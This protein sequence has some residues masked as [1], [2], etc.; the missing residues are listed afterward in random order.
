MEPATAATPVEHAALTIRGLTKSFG[1]TQA[2]AAVDLDLPRGEILALLGQNGAGKSTLVKILAG[3]VNPDAGEIR[4]DGEIHDFEQGRPSIAFIH[5]DLGLIEWM[6]VAENI[7]MAQGYKRRWGMIDW[8]AI[9]ETARASLERIA[10]GIDPRRR[11]ADL[12]RTEKS[13]VAIARA[14]G[15]HARIL[16]LDEPTAS[17]PQDDVA[18]LFDVLR[19]LKRQGVSMIYVSHR[20]DEIFAISDRLLVLRDGRAVDARRT[21]SADPES[22]VRAIIGR[23]PEKVFVRPPAPAK[24][25]PVLEC[26]GLVTGSVGPVSFA[27]ARGE[28]LGLVGLR[29]AGHE[30]ISRTLI[31]AEHHAAGRIAIRGRALDNSSIHHAVKGGLGFVAADRIAE[32]IA[33]GLS[34][35]ENMYVNPMASGAGLFTW[36][37]PAKEAA[38]ALES[39][40]RIGLVPNAPDEFIEA[41]SGGNQQKVVMARWMHIAPEV[42]ILEDP[43]A[44]VDVGAKAE[45]YR[46]LVAELAR[47]Q[48]ILLVSTDFEEVA[49]ICH[50][51]LVFRD[52][53]IVDEIAADALSTESITLAAS[54]APAGSHAP[55]EDVAQPHATH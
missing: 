20:L 50:R 52:G 15:I 25:E 19:E 27:L 41:L 8:P 30:L 51:A 49:A 17:L 12:T 9:T 24:P 3:V 42:L 48:G 43:T 37:H 40:R 34:I 14:V 28:V 26:E 46:L 23:P 47:G 36:R 38:A 31:G 44:G 5:Q 2:L 10:P 13:L 29:G 53:A 33:P 18:V 39:G 16:V 22:L 7:A 21:A 45:I 55:A 6:T 54:L 11:I 32:S 4:I 1:A 35:R